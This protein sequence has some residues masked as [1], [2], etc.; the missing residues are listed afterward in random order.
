MSQN[1]VSFNAA[2][3]MSD[4]TVCCVCVFVC[5]FVWRMIQIRPRQWSAEVT[6]KGHPAQF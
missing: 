4:L 3:R 6:N 2:V 1:T 5:V